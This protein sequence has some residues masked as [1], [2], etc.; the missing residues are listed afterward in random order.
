MTTNRT[1]FAL[2]V[3]SCLSIAVMTIM[4]DT[5]FAQIQYAAPKQ[6]C[7]L[8]ERDI[9]ESS[10]LIASV[11]HPG[12]FW[13]HNDSGHDPKLYAFDRRGKHLGTCKVD[14][15]KCKDWEDIAAMQING[16]PYLVVGDVGDNLKKREDCR[17][18]FI[19]EP[20]NLKDESKAEF[21][22]DFTYDGGPIDCEAI[23][24]DAQQH[25]I[26]LVEKIMLGVSSRVYVVPL[27]TVLSKKMTATAKLLGR[28][29]VVMAT[30]MDVSADGLR[31]I[32]GT[33]GPGY[34]FVRQPEQTWQEVFTKPGRIISLPQRRQGEAICYGNDGRTLYLTSEKKPTPL[35]EIPPIQE[36]E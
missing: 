5:S 10:G 30:G 32:I 19:P 15:S 14:K 13:T 20:K 16:Q 18:Y 8:E 31:L 29:P 27:P 21:S 17:L 34:E 11:Q 25:Q 26:I 35:F 2:I 23:A 24:Y 1:L 12:V 28:I 6:L 9:G 3:Q 7:E 36:I 22:L 4:V 33:Y